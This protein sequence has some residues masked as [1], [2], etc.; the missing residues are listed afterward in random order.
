MA[1][2]QEP[3]QVNIYIENSSGQRLKVMGASVGILAPA[4]G[5]PDGALASQATPEKR[6]IARYD[7]RATLLPREHYLVV[8]FVAAGADGIDVSDCIWDIPMMDPTGN[9]FYLR[10]EDFQNPAPA[11]Y[12]TVANI[13]TVVGK[14]L[15]DRRCRFG[16]GPIYVDIQDDTA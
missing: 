5:A 7:T 10:R 6:I 12:T 2:V 13:P 4:G 15:A 3:G 8:E 14:W 11:D 9:T 16:G 1:S